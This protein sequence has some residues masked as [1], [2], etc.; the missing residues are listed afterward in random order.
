MLIERTEYRDR[1]VVAKVLGTDVFRY[2]QFSGFSFE[3]GHA[4]TAFLG[5]A[6]TGLD[7]Y[8]GRFNECL[9][10]ECRF[11]KCVFRGTA[12]P[13]CK[14]VECHFVDCEFAADDQGNPCSADGARVYAVTNKACR[15]GE[16]LF[17]RQG[18]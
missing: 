13:G 2:C 18:F 11:I 16:F 14:F 9:F 1:E 12:F 5:C 17:T 10:A 7:W 15:G 8:W 4:S 6:F 3:G